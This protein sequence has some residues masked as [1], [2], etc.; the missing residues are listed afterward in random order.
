M[1]NLMSL[2]TTT[3]A[4]CLPLA[5]TSAIA[6]GPSSPSSC[7]GHLGSVTI[8]GASASD[9]KAEITCNPSSEGCITKNPLMIQAASEAFLDKGSISLA[10]DTKKGINWCISLE[11]AD[12]D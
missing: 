7:T 1:K 6:G 4:L 9:A 2:T 8:L 12:I 5:N 10:W 3:L 11:L